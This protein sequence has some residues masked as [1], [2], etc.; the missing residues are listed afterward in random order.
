M[1]AQAALE[2][3]TTGAAA[4][5]VAPE[6]GRLVRGAPADLAALSVD[7]LGAAPEECRDGEVLLTMVGGEVVYEA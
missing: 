3:Y 5:A 1:S 4:V 6:R 2:L 7:P